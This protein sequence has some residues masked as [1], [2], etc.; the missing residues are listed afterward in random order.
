LEHW[1]S[2]W[3]RKHMTVKQTTAKGVAKKGYAWGKPDN[4]RG[5]SGPQ[6]ARHKPDVKKR[7]RTKN[8]RHNGCWGQK[9]FIQKRE[10]CGGGKSKGRKGSER[11]VEK[12][13]A[14]LNHMRK[15]KRNLRNEESFSMGKRGVQS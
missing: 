1:Q 11:K 5:K 6:K 2:E 14:L 13:Y 4:H 3:G 10:I 8:H 12:V 7:G 9:S 15:R